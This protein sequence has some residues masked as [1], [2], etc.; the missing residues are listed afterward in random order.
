MHSRV[1]ALK[2]LM[3]LYVRIEEMHSIELQRTTAAVKE[4]EQAIDAQEETARSSSYLGRDALIAGDQMDWAA[5]RTQREVAE[6]KQQRLQQ[7]RLER[8][9]LSEQAGRMYRSS[10]LRS[11][12][13]RHVVDDAAMQ[14]A[15]KTDRQA[16]AA[17][18]DRFLA[19]RRWTDAR[20]DLRAAAEINIS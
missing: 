9:M 15:S 16:Q 1:D 20:E 6:W 14:I 11:E 3:S 10:H 17:L 5:A 8:E 12:Q 7:I 2:R 4:A 13:I 18:D 19:R